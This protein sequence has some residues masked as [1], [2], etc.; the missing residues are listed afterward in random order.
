MTHRSPTQH[1]M[2]GLKK[3]LFAMAAGFALAACSSPPDGDTEST[4]QTKMDARPDQSSVTTSSGEENQ[5]VALEGN[6]REQMEARAR[7]DLA[8][9]LSLP[10]DEIE[11]ADT[12]AVQWTDSSLGCAQRGHAY[13]PIRSEGWIITL[14]H[15]DRQTVYHA[16][17]YRAI[18][19][20]PIQAE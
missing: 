9:R 12:R 14:T 8:R 6:T 16:D 11:V 1:S 15:Q 2:H 10:V 5:P 20:P 4:R 3:Q 17:R 18:P 7:A 19:C 13:Q